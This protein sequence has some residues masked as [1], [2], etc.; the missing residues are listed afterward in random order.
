MRML[1]ANSFPFL[2]YLQHSDLKWQFLGQPHFRT[3]QL[4]RQIAQTMDCAKGRS[5]LADGC[6]NQN[7]IG[8]RLCV[9]FPE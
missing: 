9:W 5:H 1:A 3:M 7:W 4:H 8:R 6:A 2:R